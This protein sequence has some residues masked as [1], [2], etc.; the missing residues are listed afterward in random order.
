MTLHPVVAERKLEALRHAMGSAILTALVDPE[1]VEILVNPDGRL[2][3]DR[4]GA[5]RSD[6]GA[7]LNAEARERVVRL[8]ADYVGEPVTR[9][10]PRLS[11]VLP[12]TG[13]RF[14]GFF[15]PVTTAPAFSI[16]KRPA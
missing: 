10:M 15:P 5:G 7:R 6:T 1:V 4:L 13:E 14:Q 9:E 11:G 2:V 3:L 12:L 16:R 8:I